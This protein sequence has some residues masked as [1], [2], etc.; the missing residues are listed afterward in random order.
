MERLRQALD[1]AADAARTRLVIAAQ[2]YGV[3]STMTFEQPNG[4]LASAMAYAALIHGTQKRKGGTIPYISHL[5]SVSALVMEY[6]GDE[7]LA[8][9]GLL[10]DALEDCGPEHEKIIRTNYGDRVAKIVAACTDGVADEHG[11]KPEWR[12]R[13][14]AYLTHL[15]TENEGTLLVSACDKLHNARAI[16]ADYRAGHDVFSRFKA[17]RDGTRWYY[18]ELLKVFAQKLGAEAPV[19]KEL[20]VSVAAINAFS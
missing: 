14:E 8:I 13:K 15:R 17:G 1:P 11:K 2:S 16:V 18:S 7:D 20:S 6:G 10:H 9:A 19:V 4:R 3:K 5:M 12:P